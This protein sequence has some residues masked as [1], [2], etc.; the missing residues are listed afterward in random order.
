MNPEWRTKTVVGICQAIRETHDYSAC[1]VLADALEDAGF[2]YQEVLK[3]LR[4]TLE[5]WQGERLVAIIYSEETAQAVQQIEKVAGEMGPRAFCEEE[6]NYGVESQTTYERL[7]RVGHRW[8]VNVD[9]YGGEYTV[10]NGSDDL[11]D[12]WSGER[13][14]E[15]WKAYQ[16]ITGRHG[17]GNP[18]CCTC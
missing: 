8:T 4:G 12:S 15:F 6:D 13:F 11:R 2:E 5:P 7:M 14:T 18:F 10:E 17:E 9:K 3:E 1:T 16:L